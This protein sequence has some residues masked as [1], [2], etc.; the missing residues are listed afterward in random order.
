[1]WST[2]ALRPTKAGQVAAMLA[3]TCRSRLRQTASWRF[4][5]T[6]AGE[7]RVSSRSTPR[8]SVRTKGDF[9]VQF[10]RCNVNQMAEI[11]PRLSPHLLLPCPSTQR[12]LW[13]VADLQ[14]SA[15]SFRFML[16]FDVAF[17]PR[18]AAS[19]TSR[20]YWRTGA[21]SARQVGTFSRSMTIRSDLPRAR[22]V[23]AS[24]A[25]RRNCI[26]S[27]SV[28]PLTAAPYV[29]N[30]N[31]P[32]TNIRLVRRP[33]IFL[34]RASR[35]PFNLSPL[36]LAAALP[37]AAYLRLLLPAPKSIPRLGADA[38]HGW[39]PAYSPN[40]RCSARAMAGSGAI[41][42]AFDFSMRQS[43]SASTTSRNVSSASVS[44]WIT[45]AAVPVAPVD[46]SSTY[47]SKKRLGGR[48]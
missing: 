10:M 18:M 29:A 43:R 12:P 14:H 44:A 34:I 20:A 40:L 33:A 21:T 15:I 7:L 17:G 24:A 11:G 45:S 22:G 39:G 28:V 42:A 30:G 41:T 25:V 13:A 1:M 47:A 3:P 37:L 32:A 36:Y 19:H 16:P 23:N 38:R 2:Q 4:S 46:K 27:A 6:S 31:G 26:S 48:E 8:S 5:W 9:M 35:P